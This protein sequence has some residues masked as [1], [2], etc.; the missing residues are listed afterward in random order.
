[1]KADIFIIDD[2]IPFELEMLRQFL[3]A[4]GFEACYYKSDFKKLGLTV[5]DFKREISKPFISLLE[6]LSKPFREWGI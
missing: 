6:Y 1:V 4:T 2:Y 5:E 3:W